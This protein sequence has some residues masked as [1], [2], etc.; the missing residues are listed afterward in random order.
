M[1]TMIELLNHLKE[2]EESK[3]ITFVSPEP[4][5]HEFCKRV[6][7]KILETVSVI[8]IVT[9]LISCSSMNKTPSTGAGTGLYT[10]HLCH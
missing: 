1:A 8:L 2:L 10:K 3:K 5:T 9:L 4:R 6:V 7:R